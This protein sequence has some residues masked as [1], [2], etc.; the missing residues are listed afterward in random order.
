MTIYLYT[1]GSM[2]LVFAASSWAQ[3]I[4]DP[5][6]NTQNMERRQAQELDAQQARA[7]GVLMCCPV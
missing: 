2:L 1:L 4:P 6:A 5:L 3:D 7:Q